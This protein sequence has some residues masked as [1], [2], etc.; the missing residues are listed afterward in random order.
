MKNRSPF[1][2]IFSILLGSAVAQTAEQAEPVGSLTDDYIVRRWGVA[3]GIPEAIVMHVTQA[4]DGYLWITTPTRITRF[5]GQRFVTLSPPDCPPKLPTLLRGVHFDSRGDFWIYGDE[6]VWHHQ[7]DTWKQ[8]IGKEEGGRTIRL[9]DA[10]DGRIVCVAQRFLLFV[11][12]TGVERIAFQGEGMINDAL[13]CPMGSL[14]VA[15]DD[16][17]YRLSNRTFEKEGTLLDPD[18]Y[19]ILK[20][21]PSGALLVKGRKG[22]A[23]REQVGWRVWKGRELL[24]ERKI[25]SDAILLE[26]DEDFWGAGS[27][28]GHLKGDDYKELGR[29]DGFVTST[30]HHLFKDRAGSLWLATRGGLYQLRPR[31]VQVVH[32]TTGMGKDAF[33]AV[34]ENKDGTLLCGVDGGGLLHGTTQTLRPLELQGFPQNSAVSALLTGRDG[35]LWIGTQGDFLWSREAQNG[36]LHRNVRSDESI[37]S[38]LE[39]RDGTIYAGTWSGLRRV[40]WETAAS[41]RIRGG[42]P[43]AAVHAL[44]EDRAGQLWAGHQHDGLVGFSSTQVLVRVR[45]AEG[46]PDSSVRALCEDEK[47]GLWIGT[48]KG[49]VWRRNNGQ[50]VVFGENEGLP[51]SDIRQILKDGNNGL[52]LSTA[53]GIVHIDRTD[54]EAVAQKSRKTLR[55]SEYGIPEGLVS[56]EC[57]AGYGHT[58]LRLRDGRLLFCTLRGLAVITPHERPTASKVAATARLEEIKVGDSPLWSRSLITRESVPKVELPAGTRQVFIRYAVPEFQAPDRILFRHRLEGYEDAWSESSKSRTIL[59]Q[60]LPP[61]NYALRLS[62]RLRNGDWTEQ[63]ILV[64]LTLP[65]L[66]RQ[67]DTFKAL[68]IFCGLLFVGSVVWYMERRRNLRRIA[69]L[70]H[71][72]AIEQERSR[73]ARD[74]HDDIGAALTRV[75]ILGNLTQ[76]DAGDRESTHAHGQELFN[77]AQRMT[78][79][80]RE[81]VWALNPRSG[82]TE[83]CI[84]FM[85]QYAQQ[86]LGESGHHCRLNIPDTVPEAIVDARA[87]HALLM[88]FKEALNNAVKHA[89][90]TGL[91]VRFA[92]EE[93]RLKVSVEDKGC[94][95]DVA[96]TEAARRG[97]GIEAMRQRMHDCGGRF[98]MSSQPGDG[99]TVLLEVPLVEMKRRT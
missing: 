33:L 48:M 71:E 23:I 17:L 11:T 79:S 98:E 58:S 32:N 65:A 86:F 77:T 88:A 42:M 46:L 94:G 7:G 56:E 87:R 20:I 60:N 13:F 73:I 81:I 54:A 3:D 75:A 45:M 1:L 40:G 99:T 10:P 41:L 84:N 91:N 82:T 70:E 64:A 61:G 25:H 78:R 53:A 18:R 6:G 38:L 21:T 30:V 4:P 76:S 8:I 90:A 29:R 28:V 96:A 59:Y 72:R 12:D 14:R 26:S 47:D 51:D 16:G 24:Y 34:I 22:F 67:T 37:S 2:F 9:L 52:W 97:H 5:D 31:T 44:L 85:T 35:S 89:G 43:H 55:V 83:D 19:S 39:A 92:F 66:F 27:V 63:G 95:M 93:K 50:L 74:L 62:M 68:L 69:I 49:L 36:I 57:P 15:A 80:L